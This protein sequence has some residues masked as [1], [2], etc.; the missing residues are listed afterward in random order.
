MAQAGLAKEEA[1]QWGCLFLQ[2]LSG[3]GQ[4]SEP[5]TPGALLHSCTVPQ[6]AQ[7]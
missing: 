5:D 2:G 1:H 6:G 3:G 7:L 4:Q